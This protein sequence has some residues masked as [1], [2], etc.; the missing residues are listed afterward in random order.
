MPKPVWA[1]T[2]GSL[3]RLCQSRSGRLHGLL[4]GLGLLDQCLAGQRRLLRPAV[5]DTG[6]FLPGLRRGQ[7]APGHRLRLGVALVRTCPGAARDQGGGADQP[8]HHGGQAGADPAVHRH[9]RP[10]V[11]SRRLHAGYLGAQQPAV[12]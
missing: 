8:G 1:I 2:W 9:R 7:Y 5:L 4:F 6:L 3:I 10:G 12:R 11:R